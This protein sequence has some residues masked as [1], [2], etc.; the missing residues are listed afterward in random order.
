MGSEATRLDSN[1]VLSLPVCGHA[2]SFH[3]YC[4]KSRGRVGG[5]R[6]KGVGPRLSLSFHHSCL[7]FGT[8]VQA[9]RVGGE[10][11]SKGRGGAVK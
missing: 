1:A 5:E 9:R 10:R 2:W 6:G 8:A 11:G 4:V 3:N 7:V